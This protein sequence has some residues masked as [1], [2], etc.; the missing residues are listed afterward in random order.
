VRAAA[1]DPVDRTVDELTDAELAAEIERLAPIRRDA[2]KGRHFQRLSLHELAI[3]LGTSPAMCK[4]HA[5]KGLRD[6]RARL[7]ARYIDFCPPGRGARH[8]RRRAVGRWARPR[9]PG[10]WR[11][12]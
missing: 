4:K 10:D 12:S 11:A 1:P 7:L 6:L 5:L 9:G 2:V 3:R 8:G